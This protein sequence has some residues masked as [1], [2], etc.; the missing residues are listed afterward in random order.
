[1]KT[2]EER[3]TA[4]IDGRLAGAELEAFERELAKHPEAEAD[5]HSARQ[6]GDL[7]RRYAAPALANADFFS[8]QLASRIEAENRRPVPRRG[9]AWALPHLGWAGACCLLLSFALYK[10][11]VSPAPVREKQPAFAE[12][13]SAP[14]PEPIAQET[15]SSV[16][17]LDADSG[18][19]GVSVSRVESGDDKTAVLWVDGLE[20]L[21]A[22]YRLE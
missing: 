19:P 3:Y 6:L 15:G 22:D 9:F 8:R 20:Y 7:L 14:T 12:A 5:R 1:M 16:Q 2:F 11:L 13:V 18:D 4:W 10:T 21:P 17:I